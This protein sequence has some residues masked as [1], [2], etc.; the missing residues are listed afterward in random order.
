MAIQR[1]GFPRVSLTDKYYFYML[2][3]TFGV[4]Q[5]KYTKRPLHQRYPKKFLPSY[6]LSLFYPFTF[7]MLEI[8]SHFI[9]TYYK[10]KRGMRGS[11]SR[12]MILRCARHILN[13]ATQHLSPLH[14]VRPDSLTPLFEDGSV[15]I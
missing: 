10:C 12:S 11:G 9:V 5:L 6:H 1:T 13:I 7:G 4:L 15:V 2:Y 14:G 3:G 8:L